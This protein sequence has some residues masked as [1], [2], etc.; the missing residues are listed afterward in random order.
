MSEL[1]GEEEA[2]A[3]HARSRQKCP[4][5]FPPK[6]EG[7]EKGGGKKSFRLEGEKGL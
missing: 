6:Q 4:P 2:G 5:P 3:R 1:F 7:A